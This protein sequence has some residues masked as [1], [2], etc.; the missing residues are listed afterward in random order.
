MYRPFGRTAIWTGCRSSSARASASSTVAGASSPSARRRHQLQRLPAGVAAVLQAHPL[1]MAHQA[2][3]VVD[4]ERRRLAGL[5]VAVVGDRADVDPLRA[6]RAQDGSR[7]RR[8]LELHL[9]RREDVAAVGADPRR[10]RVDGLAC[11]ADLGRRLAL[12]LTVRLVP[13]LHQVDRPVAGDVAGE[14]E[15]QA[16]LLA[17][18]EPR[19]AAGHLDVE[20]GRLGRPQHG[21]QVDRRRVEAGGQHAHRGQ[22][23]DL[24]ALERGDDAVAL[25]LRG[26]AEDGGAGDAP[27]TNGVADVAGVVDPGAEQQPRAPVPAVVDDLVDRRPGD[28]VLVDRGLELR[29]R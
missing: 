22:R 26:V 27:G 17:R 25:G 24:A 15:H 11:G 18:G 7:G 12:A 4:P 1:A 14:V 20:A 5:L 8:G 13:G 21:D 2:A 6:A 10:Q 9:R 23:P 19:A 16:V 3:V 29:R 28:R